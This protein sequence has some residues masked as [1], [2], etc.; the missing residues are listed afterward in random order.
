[1]SPKRTARIETSG[2]RMLC[3]VFRFV[4]KPIVM[5]YVRT[6]WKLSLVSAVCVFLMCDIS[7]VCVCVCVCAG[8]GRLI[9]AS[10]T[11]EDVPTSFSK[12]HLE[13]AASAN[14]L[15][16]VTAVFRQSLKQLGASSSNFQSETSVSITPLFVR[17]YHGKI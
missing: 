2:K 11:G 8:N 5:I 14:R 3:R 15:E 4:A 17:N 12:A 9:L 7:C 1:M 10:V 16:F 13:K 6:V